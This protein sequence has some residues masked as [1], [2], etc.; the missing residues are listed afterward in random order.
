MASLS[1]PMVPRVVI[2]PMLAFDARGFRLGYGG[3]F[4]DRTLARLAASSPVRAI[5]LAFAA[6]E[7]PPLPLEPTDIALDAIVTE[8]GVIR[9]A[10]QP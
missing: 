5:G 10:T 2:V 3:G 6:Q 8:T 9:P 4:Y 7:L 1:Q